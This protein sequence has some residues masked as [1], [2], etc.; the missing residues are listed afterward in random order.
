MG[1]DINFCVIPGVFAKSTARAVQLV[2][3]SRVLRGTVNVPFIEQLL[4]SNSGDVCFGTQTHEGFGLRQND[5]CSIMLLTETPLEGLHV[6]EGDAGWSKL[7]FTVWFISLGPFGAPSL[8]KTEWSEAIRS[9]EFLLS[10]EADS[11][12]SEARAR[13]LTR[14]CLCKT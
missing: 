5:S 1:F 13:A 9:T 7:P 14:R 6:S 8:L 11:H 12:H 10:L 3:V 4:R 2:I